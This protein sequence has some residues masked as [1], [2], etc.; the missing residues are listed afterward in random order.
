MHAEFVAA[1]SSILAFAAEYAIPHVVKNA[2]IRRLRAFC[3]TQRLVA[4]TYDDGPG[5]ELTPIIHAAL[6]AHAAR[7]TFFPTATSAARAPELLSRLTSDGHEIGCHSATHRHA[8]R[9]LPPFALRDMTA[10]FAFLAGWVPDNGLFRPPYGKLTASTWLVA[11]MKGR[12]LA[13]WTVDSG[14]THATLPA[15]D[16]IMTRI[17]LDRGGVL[18]LHDFDRLGPESATRRDFVVAVTVRALVLAR[19]EGL[20]IVT[21]GEIL[22]RM[23]SA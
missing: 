7:A 1:A 10:G 23:R 16:A 17:A 15:P 11:A 18:L 20:T 22:R 19:R 21:L 6:A 2:T 14:D 8:W 4:L 5:L 12:R 13:W 3:R 9:T